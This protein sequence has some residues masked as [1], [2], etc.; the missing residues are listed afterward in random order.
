MI[1][2]RARGAIRGRKRVKPGKFTSLN[3]SKS[4]ACV[5]RR[6]KIGPADEAGGVDSTR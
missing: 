3:L 4:G 6:G 5:S 1:D 2:L